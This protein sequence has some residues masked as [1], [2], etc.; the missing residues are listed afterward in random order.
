[1]APWSSGQGRL[2]LSQEVTGS[3]PVG[4][5]NLKE[6]FIMDDHQLLFE[7]EVMLNVE[8]MRETDSD[9]RDS[10][11]KASTIKTLELLHSRFKELSKAEYDRKLNEKLNKM[12]G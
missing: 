8:R 11:L 7:L 5:T 12:K 10:Y 6:E 4:A 3:N 9:P 2:V 1:M